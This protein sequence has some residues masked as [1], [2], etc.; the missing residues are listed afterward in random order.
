MLAE[1]MKPSAPSPLPVTVL[2]SNIDK[3]VIYTIMLLI[4][5]FHL[6]NTFAFRSMNRFFD[7]VYIG[8]GAHGVCYVCRMPMPTTNN[9]S[10]RQSN[11]NIRVVIKQIE[12]NVD[13]KE[14]SMILCCVFIR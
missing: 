4:L 2:H 9:H 12:L 8:R 7:K 3:T 13:D 5:T 6:Q 14:L 1:S 10:D 11:G